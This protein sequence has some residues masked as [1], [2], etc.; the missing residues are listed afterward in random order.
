MQTLTA[1]EGKP[2][3]MGSPA[4]NTGQRL[5][6]SVVKLF[7]LSCR[8]LRS[9]WEKTLFHTMVNGWFT[10]DGSPYTAA[11]YRMIPPAGE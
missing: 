11:K 8:A 5:F 9:V 3:S 1:L 2:E 10:G 6:K 7:I 4:A